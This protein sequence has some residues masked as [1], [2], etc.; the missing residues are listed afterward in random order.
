MNDPMAHNIEQWSRTSLECD[1][2]PYTGFDLFYF[3]RYVGRIGFLFFV[4]MTVGQKRRKGN[5]EVVLECAYSLTL[6]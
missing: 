4:W 5:R 6:S 1:A 3:S 2:A